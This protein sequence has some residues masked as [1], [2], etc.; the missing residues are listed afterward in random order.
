M[1]RPHC[2]PDW[3]FAQGRFAEAV[4]W[5]ENSPTTAMGQAK[6]LAVAAKTGPAIP[7][8]NTPN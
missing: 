1:P 5:D 4:F 8:D 6:I 2:H 7:K 3:L